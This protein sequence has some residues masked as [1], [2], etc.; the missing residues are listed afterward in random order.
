MLKVNLSELLC[1]RLA[2]YTSSL[3]YLGAKML[4]V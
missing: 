2:F 4:H 3:F 1:L